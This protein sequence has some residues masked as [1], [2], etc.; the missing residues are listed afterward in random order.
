MQIKG[1]YR[2]SSYRITEYDNGVFWWE[3]H[4]DFGKQRSGECF[5][6]GN[7]LIIKPWSNEK[8]GLLIGEFLDQLKKLPAWDKTL[9]Y[10]F[11]S[12]LLEVK[13]GGELRADLWKPKGSRMDNQTVEADGAAGLLPGSYRIDRYRI[14]I[15]D[16]GAISWQTPGGMN[17]IIGGPG[18]IESGILFLGPRVGG[19]LKQ[20]KLDFL[21]RLSRLPHWTTTIAWCRYP[22]LRSCQEKKQVKSPKEI[23]TQ[24]KKLIDPVYLEHPSITPQSP[25]MESSPKQPPYDFTLLKSL[26]SFSSWLNK[27]N[28]P[29]LSWPWPSGKKFWVPGLILFVLSG[30]IIMGII[31]FHVLEEKF[32]RPPGY[33]N[34]H[35]EHRGEH[36]SKLGLMINFLLILIA[37]FFILPSNRPAYGEEKGIILEESG[38]H[39]PGGFDLN[40]VGEVQ[41][42]VAHCSRPEKGPVR[43]QLATDRE[44]YTVL[45]SPHWYWHENQVKISEGIE[46]SVRGS[47]SFGRDGKLYIVAQ[48]LRIPSSGQY[49]VFRG[50]DG[51]PLWK[52]HTRSGRESQNEFG[53]SSDERGGVGSGGGSKGQGR[54]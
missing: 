52:G 6:H 36:H 43:F 31:A 48:E 11:F 3:T 22:A 53:S 33:K 21:Y 38:I 10:C 45:T 47:K 41:G 37:L 51:T 34:N 9:Y 2:L 4:F 32:N 54:R 49:F 24:P 20:S 16:D 8:D 25:K 7:I 12:E 15:N 13:T 14:T 27:I 29:K 23:S 5:I 28:R 50:K 18:L 46:V 44:L 30:L 17:R 19:E 35:H 1:S 26:P 39:Y 40:T 42:K